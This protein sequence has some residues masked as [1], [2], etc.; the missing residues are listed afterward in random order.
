M[1]L[2]NGHIPLLIFSVISQG[3]NRKNKEWNTLIITLQ[4]FLYRRRSRPGYAMLGTVEKQV[5]VSTVRHYFSSRA[6][7]KRLLLVPR[8]CTEVR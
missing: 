8:S 6:G 3:D 4:S 7:L 1:E 2:D 5:G